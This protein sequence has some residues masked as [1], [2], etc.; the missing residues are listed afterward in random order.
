LNVKIYDIDFQ[1]VVRWNIRRKYRMPRILAL[2]NAMAKPI[3]MLYQD[4][5]NYRT[6]KLYDL[7]ITPQVCY[8]EALLRDRY[9]YTQRRIYITDAI[10][11]PPLYL[12][13]DAE[14]HPINLYTD[15]EDSPVYLYTDG[16]GSDYNNDFIVWVPA[17][18]N[19]SYIEMYSLIY[20]KRLPGMRFKIQTF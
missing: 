8:L 19:F 10:D 4:F 5:L 6:A 9:D 18:I 17:D 11:F 1:S 2:L 14:L 13:T 16:E 3:V 15:S 12:Y 7:M 20:K